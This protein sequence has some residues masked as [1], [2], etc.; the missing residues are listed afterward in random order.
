[1]ARIQVNRINAILSE[2]A[3]ITHDQVVLAVGGGAVSLVV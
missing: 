3:G 1:M 2:A